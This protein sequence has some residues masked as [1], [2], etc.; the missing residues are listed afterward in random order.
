MRKVF[1]LRQKGKGE[2]AVQLLERMHAKNPTPHAR[3]SSWRSSTSSTSVCVMQPAS[4]PS[5]SGSTPSSCA[6]GSSWPRSTSSSPTA[7]PTGTQPATRWSSRTIRSITTRR[8]SAPQQAI[9]LGLVNEQ[10]YGYLGLTLLARQ[11]YIEAETAFRSALAMSDVDKTLYKNWRQGLVQ[12]Y[13]K[14]RR[15][16]DAAA[17]LGTLIDEDARRPKLWLFQ[18]NAY[19]GLGDAQRWRRTSR[20]PTSSGCRRPRPPHPRRHLRQRRT[21]G[22]RGGSLPRGHRA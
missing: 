15:Y 3:P 20:S 4:T 16:A 7:P 21:R 5:R 10:N 9:G 22:G 18:G 19:I 17:M 12:S 8:R 13:F 2:R 11:R 1:E 14:Q 6:R